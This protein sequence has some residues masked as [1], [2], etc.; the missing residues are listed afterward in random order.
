V[1]RSESVL[2]ELYPT[3]HK[4]SIAVVSLNDPDR[5]NA[6]NAEIVENIIS[7][8]DEFDDRESNVGAVVITGV[9]KAF[10]AGADLSH[11]EHSGS[12]G[13]D[14][15]ETNLR[16]IY[17]GFLRIA[18]SK[19]PTIAAVNGPAVGAGMNLAMCCDLRI[20]G[21]SARFD[22]RFLQLGL[23]PGG[24]HLW[25]LRQLVGPQNAAAMVLFGQVMGAN[26]ALRTGLVY[27]VAE[28][29]D[30]LD[31]AKSYAEHATAPSRDLMN[32][33]K[34]L[35]MLPCVEHDQAIDHEIENQLWSMAQPQFAER[36]TDFRRRRQP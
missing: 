16:D 32:R 28:D 36:L 1:T 25:M 19:L 2:I 4:S 8:F 23:H 20:A 5:R 18:H 10:C 17:G 33:A 21:H 35:M 3:Q 26:D 11:L 22:S 27:S 12:E 13:A 15:R 6:L 7:A 14:D 34:E 30:L 9:G 29:G 24:G 31:V